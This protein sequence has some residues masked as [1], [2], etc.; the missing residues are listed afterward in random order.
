MNY[1]IYT[2]LVNCCG[3]CPRCAYYRPDGHECTN[4]LLNTN[5]SEMLDLLDNFDE[6]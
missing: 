3:D 5:P 2:K 4:P 6:D 1:D